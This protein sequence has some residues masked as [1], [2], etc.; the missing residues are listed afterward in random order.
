[1]TGRN[2]RDDFL[3][4]LGAYFSIAMEDFEATLKDN[5]EEAKILGDGLDGENLDPADY[6]TQRAECIV[7]WERN[8]PYILAQEKNNDYDGNGGQFSIIQRAAFDFWLTRNGHGAG[9]WDRPE[10]WGCYSDR[11]TEDSNWFGV[12]DMVISDEGMVFMG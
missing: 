12:V 3:E 11:L 5:G 2:K 6:E 1:M 7:F 9:F 4:F 10:L 8:G